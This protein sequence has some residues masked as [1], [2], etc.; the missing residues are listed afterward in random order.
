[1]KKIVFLLLLIAQ[2]SFAQKYGGD[3]WADV[4]SKGSGKLAIVYYPQNGLIAQEGGKMKGLCVDLL[5]DFVAYVQTKHN[6][7]ITLD[8]QGEE[9]VFSEFLK[10]TENTPNL[11]GVTYV[12][13]TEERK[14][15]MKFTPPFLSNQETLIT[16][17]DA[18]ALTS[19][20]NISTQLKG[21]SAK[22]IAESVHQ[23]YAEQ[24]K[25]ENMPGLIISTGPSGTEILKEI[26][27]NPKL[28]TILDFTEYVDAARK[29]LPVKRQNVQIGPIQD[30]AF[31]MSKQS[32]WDEIWNEFLTPEY[33]KSEKYRKAIA[34]HLGGAYLSVFK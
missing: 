11:L 6:K 17:K 28:F 34:T 31:A 21:Y 8:Y 10:A 16:H 14:K 5:N 25:Q 4:K 1:M 3:S 29:H 20:K 18:P 26:S 9:K 27:T 12:T 22:V 7:K 2:V 30:L 23:K 19:L 15:I 24:I 32:D 13:V 33:R